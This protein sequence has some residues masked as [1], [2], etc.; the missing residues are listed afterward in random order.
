[1]FKKYQG[2]DEN[3]ASPY[4]ILNVRE[5]DCEIESSEN[6]KREVVHA[7][8]LARFIVDAVADPLT[9]DSEDMI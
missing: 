1:M 5:N 6:K 7:N 8:N 2:L 3:Y 4:L 9:E